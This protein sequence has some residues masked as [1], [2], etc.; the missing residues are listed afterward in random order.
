MDKVLIFGAAGRVGLQI[1]AELLRRGLQ[2]AMVDLLPQQRLEQIGRRLLID[3]RLAS[4]SE[5]AALSI[6]GGIDALDQHRVVQVLA[7]EKPDLVINYA[8]PITWDATKQLPNYERISAAG[9]GAFTPIQVFTPWI[10]GRAIAE[11][12][13]DCHYMVGNLPDITIPIL[14]GLTQTRRPVC[15]AGNV[16]LIAAAVRQQASIE[17]ETQ[18][19]DIQVALVA[20][21]IHW[22]APREPGYPQDAPFLLRVSVGDEDVTATLGDSRAIINNAIVD[23]YEP[24]AAFSSTTGILASRAAIALLDGSG[25]SSRLH[26]PAPNGLAGGYPVNITAGVITPQLPSCWTAKEAAQAMEQAQQRDGVDAIETNGT[27]RFSQR[28][29]DILKQ[30]L[31]FELPA[32][33]N[34]GDIEAVAREQIA[35]VSS[36]FS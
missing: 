9:L 2:V 20:H 6:H 10:I 27:A 4:P 35:V 5:T 14:C 25:R 26:V 21:H 8:I 24:G 23:C 11:L 34:E 19:A 3:S 36:H 15:G 30:E 28:A 16:G 32:V 12:E 31:G 7:A 18:T 22:V 1:T 29:R 33:M 17:L 13:L